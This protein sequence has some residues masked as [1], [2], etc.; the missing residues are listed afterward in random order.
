MVEAAEFVTPDGID[1]ALL[2]TLVGAVDPGLLIFELPGNWIAGVHAHEVHAMMVHLT[3]RLGPDVNIA[4]VPATDLVVL[5][6]L[7]TGLGV[8]GGSFGDGQA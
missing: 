1:E 8:T 4:N 7:R 5:E 3:E 6:T 2:D